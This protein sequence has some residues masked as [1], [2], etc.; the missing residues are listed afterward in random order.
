[1]KKNEGIICGNGGKR[2]QKAYCTAIISGE[3]FKRYNILFFFFKDLF[4]PFSRHLDRL[5]YRHFLLFLVRF[6]PPPL[7]FKRYFSIES[8]SY[9]TKLFLYTITGKNRER[10]KQNKGYCPPWQTAGWLDATPVLTPSPLFFSM[11]KCSPP[12]LSKLKGGIDFDVLYDQPPLF[13]LRVCCTWLYGGVIAQLL[14]P[15]WWAMSPS[16]AKTRKSKKERDNIKP[17]V[18][19]GGILTN[20]YYKKIEGEDI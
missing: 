13:I 17:Q 20:V 19:V 1:M 18:C 7:F 12:Q 8:C 16:L 4:C 15:P 14:T 9:A 5:I 2:S 6:S 10:K 11:Y 3:C